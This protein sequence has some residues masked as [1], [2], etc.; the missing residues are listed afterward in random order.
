MVID[1]TTSPSSTASL[2]PVTGTVCAMFQVVAVKVSEAGDTVASAMFDDASGTV[3]SPVGCE[4][5]TIVKVA[6][7]PAASVTTSGPPETVTPAVSSS[8]VVTLTG[9]G[10]LPL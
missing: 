1:E 10:V 5:S 7:E 6:V 2:T 8:M 9:A 4:V 3:T